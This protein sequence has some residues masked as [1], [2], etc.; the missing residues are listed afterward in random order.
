M[1]LD[2]FEP[3]HQALQ[4]MV[5]TRLDLLQAGKVQLSLRPF[6]PRDLNQ[7]PQPD[8]LLLHGHDANI[9]TRI[10]LGL[11]IFRK[12]LGSGSQERPQPVPEG[13]HPRQD[14]AV[15]HGPAGAGQVDRHDAE[16]GADSDPDRQNL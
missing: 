1:F 10:R 9:K 8:P 14:E 6:R 12:E 5:G 11:E 13:Q 3:G 15:R 16:G 2:R 7:P 4:R